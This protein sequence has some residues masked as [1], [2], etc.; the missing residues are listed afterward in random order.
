MATLRTLDK[1]LN[2]IQE[3]RKNEFIWNPRLEHMPNEITLSPTFNIQRDDESIL[4]AEVEKVRAELQK[5]SVNIVTLI[6]YISKHAKAA[7]DL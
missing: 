7:G 4:V 2:A 5:E 1:L 3:G 6:S